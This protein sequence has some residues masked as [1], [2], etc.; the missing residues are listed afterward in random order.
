M[1]IIHT[2][3][4]HLGAALKNLPPEKA[5]MRKAELAE[6]FRRLCLYARENGVS[7]V[8]I[9]G[10]LFDSDN[11]SSQ[12]RKEFFKV[13]AAAKPVCFF[14]ISGNHDE[15]LEF[16]EVPPDNLYFFGEYHA[17]KSYDLPENVTVTGIDGK[18][19]DAQAYLRLSLR[20]DRYNIVM[21]HGE[22]SKGEGTGKESISLL[23]LQNK[24]IDYLALGHIHQ[25]TLSVERI[26]GRGHFRYC[27][28]LEG[29]GF[30]ECGKRGFFLLDVREGRL[31]SESFLS[32]AKREICEEVADISACQTY[33]D[34]ERTAM[35]TLKEQS[36][37]NQIKL[38]LRGRHTAALKK[39]IP[40]LTQ[41]LN[42]RFFFV[43][44]VDESRVYVDY[45]AFAADVSER[46]EF[47]REV[48]RYEM[49][50]DFRAEILEVGLKALA[51]EEIDL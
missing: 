21:M 10:D 44:V 34:V 45:S 15:W 8:L 33:F 31:V 17:W 27:G 13:V 46:G 26:D 5:R 29:R 24:G 7:V 1:K 11:I 4:I 38:I 37:E 41:R 12:W 39:D 42:E 48:G 6:T 19:M 9:A 2:G 36:A 28:C 3:D 25:P 40:L 32:L 20:S 51:G 23:R 30:D 22:I 43:K 47:V 35:E 49:N 18:N 50:E 14:Y 16:E